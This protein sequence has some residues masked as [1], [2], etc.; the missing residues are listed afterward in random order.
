MRLHILIVIFNFVWRGKDKI[1]R[2][3][4]ISEYEDGGLKMP[5]P[6]SLIKTQ[7]IACLKRYL[8]DHSRPWKVFLSHYLKNVGTSFL[9]Q[10]NFTPSRL[11]C[12]L[13]IF[14]EECLEVSSNF[15]GN[16]DTIATKQDVLNE[17]IWNNQNLLINKQSMYKK[18]I[19]EAGYLKLGDILSNGSKLKSWDAFREK[20]LSLSDYLLLQGIFSAIPPNWKLSL[21]DGENFFFF[22]FF[23]FR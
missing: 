23:F 17:I 4:L 9:L 13:P 21:K 19:K 2:L 15:N 6:E 12:K 16:H 3:A 18:R 14:Y 11:P 10:S 7:R 8:D 22:F 1:K 5:H 20:N